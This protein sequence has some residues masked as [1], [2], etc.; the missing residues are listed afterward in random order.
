[1]TYAWRADEVSALVVLYSIH[2]SAIWLKGD[3]SDLRKVDKGNAPA[4][5][6]LAEEVVVV[7]YYISIYLQS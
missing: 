2:T 7:V 4:E 3:T 1:M 6:V 5:E